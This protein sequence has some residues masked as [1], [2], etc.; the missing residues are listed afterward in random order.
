M[1]A[2]KVA[3]AL[4]TAEAQLEAHDELRF[5]FS[6]EPCAIG[7]N[8]ANSAVDLLAWP[9]A[10]LQGTETAARLICETRPNF[11]SLGNCCV[12]TYTC[13]TNRMPFCYTK[14]SL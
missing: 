8:C 2:E 7:R 5:Q 12:R 1:D 14:R 11:S 3:G 13:F 10:M 4:L 9:S 6:S